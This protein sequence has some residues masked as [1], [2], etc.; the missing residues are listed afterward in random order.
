LDGKAGLHPALGLAPA[1]QHRDQAMFPPAPPG[2]TLRRHLRRPTMPRRFAL[3]LPRT[4]F[5]A[6]MTLVLVLLAGIAVTA[7][8]SGSRIE[9]RLAP[10]AERAVDPA[11]VVYQLAQQVDMARGLAALHVLGAE[12]AEA[13]LLEQRVADHQRAVARQ[14]TQFERWLAD[15]DD[16]RHHA[17]VKAALA[18]CWQL[19]EQ[20]LEASRRAGTE[21]HAAAEARRLLAGESQQCHQNL[22]QTLDAWWR[23]LD[24]RRTAAV[25]R[26]KAELT[27]LCWHIAALAGLAALAL[28][29]LGRRGTPL[30]PAPSTTGGPVTRPPWQATGGDLAQRRQLAREATDHARRQAAASDGARASGRSAAPPPHDGPS[31][32][33]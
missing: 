29:A 18:A 1:A 32:G 8:L 25:E 19:Q 7:V 6:V 14:L 16:R 20:V 21:P 26:I 17:A 10:L 4:R 31:D 9:A 23:H 33:P 12:A 3:P 11:N 28:A 27:A 15:D 30:P 5:G 24:Q 22:H 2:A 13:R